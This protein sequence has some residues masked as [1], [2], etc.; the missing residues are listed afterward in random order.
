MVGRIVRRTA[1]MVLVVLAV[2][3]ITFFVLRIAAGDPARLVNP[4]GTPENI[5]TQTRQRLGLTGSL[6]AQY[7]HFMAGLIRGDL[8]TSFRGASPVAGVVTKA[9]PNTLA[10][11]AVT[12][13]IASFV[14]LVLGMAAALRPNGLLD[15]AVLLYVAVGWATPSF[16]LAVILVFFFSLKLGWFPAIDLRGPK[17]FVLPV[18]TLVIALTPILI[19][20]VRQSFLETMTEDFIRAA[21]ARGLP[22]RR[23]FLVHGLK[24]AALPLVTLIGLQ[25][26]FI[27][28]GS[29]VVESIFNWPGI[30]RLTLN[31]VASRDFPMIQGA[32]LVAAVSFVLVNFLVDLLY[33]VL[34]PRIRHAR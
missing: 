34:D 22:E 1:G 11:A 4:P 3:T 13:V 28:A 18:A 32:V 9:L 8:G 23:V 7:G 26:G 33:S 20:T 27:L 5:I 25:M 16:W 21:R 29:Y 17:S 12:M 30:G 14:A 2:V 19:R 6:M 31:A 24:V 10:L 15:R